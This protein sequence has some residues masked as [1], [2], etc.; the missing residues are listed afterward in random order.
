MVGKSNY[1][2]IILV[3]IA[4]LVLILGICAGMYSL[5]KNNI[6]KNEIT[7]K[8]DELTRIKNKLQSYP[9]L[10]AEFER[11]KGEIDRLATYIPNEEGQAEF[12]KELQTWT[13]KNEVSL[14]SC[15]VNS[16]PLVLEKLPNYLIYRWNVKL[17]CKYHNLLSLIKDITNGSRF[18][19]VSNVGA[20]RDKEDATKL[21]IELSLDLISKK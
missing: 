12:V 15:M 2:N 9:N 10:E 11:L 7:A 4:V 6:I 18:V 1:N 20:E 13:D 14:N 21:L 8:Q 19:L 5:S 3:V 17:A 16:E